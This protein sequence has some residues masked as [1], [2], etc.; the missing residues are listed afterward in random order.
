MNEQTVG[1]SEAGHKLADNKGEAAASLFNSKIGNR[2]PELRFRYMFS[3]LDVGTN[4]KFAWDLWIKFP[5]KIP[6][7]KTE[8]FKEDVNAL[9]QSTFTD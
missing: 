4:Q 6:K 7:E 5:F 3:E 9:F 2:K 1:S 8:K